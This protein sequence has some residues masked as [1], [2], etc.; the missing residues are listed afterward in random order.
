MQQVLSEEEV[1]DVGGKGVAQLQ[2]A[3]GALVGR[4]GPC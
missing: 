1:G 4:G 2:V 3:A